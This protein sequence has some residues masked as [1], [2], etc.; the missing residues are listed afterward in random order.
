[1]DVAAW[2]GIFLLIVGALLVLVRSLR[3]LMVRRERD[4]PTLHQALVAS[5]LTYRVFFR[6]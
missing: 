3:S 4:Y 6:R 5:H 2:V 1:M